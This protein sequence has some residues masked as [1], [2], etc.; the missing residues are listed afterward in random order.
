MIQRLAAAVGGGLM[1][2]GLGGAAV[3]WW[4]APAALRP[5][6]GSMLGMVALGAVM[7]GAGAAWLLGRVVAAHLG[8]AR[9]LAEDIDVL[10]AVDPG[11]EVGVDVDGTAA[12]EIGAVAGSV[13]GLVA[14]LREA[15]AERD[16][17]V[18]RG[19]AEAE[20]DRHRLG[21]VMASLAH[22]VLVCGGDGRILLYNEA[23]VGLFGRGG[24]G[25][26]P[27]GLGR[28]VFTLVSRSALVGAVR[29]LEAGGGE[30]IRLAVAG[31]ED[32]L[33]RVTVA[34][35]APVAAV[36]PIG[37]RGETGEGRDDLAG[38]VLVMDD[39]TA[40]SEA[41]ATLDDL[42]RATLE[43]VR[44]R[45]AAIVGAIEMLERFDNL[46]GDDVT[47][48]RRIISEESQRL[49]SYLEAAQ[50]SHG[51][52]GVGRWELTEI[53]ARDLVA[54]ITHRAGEDGGGAAGT[55]VE[56]AGGSGDLWFRV[57]AG[58]VVDEVGGAVVALMA[59][60]AERVRLSW[61]SRG[62]LGAVVVAWSDASGGS[63]EVVRALV[64]DGRVDGLARRHGGEAWVEAAPGGEQASM[65]VLLPSIERPVGPAGSPA[66]GRSALE[67]GRDR[68]TVYDFSLLSERTVDG[69]L[70]G[71]GL[72]EL[73]CTVFDL[74]TTGL[75]PSND[76][77]LSIGAVRI[78]NGNLL[79]HETFDQL[80]DPGRPIPPS[81]TS[82]HGITADMVAGQPTLAEALP[83][84]ARF[85]EQ[86]VLIGHN[87]AFD[88]RFLELQQGVT[89]VV[90]ANAVLDTLVLG[91]LALGASGSHSLESLGEMLGVEVTGR[92][93]ALG[94][95][96]V[97]AEI[98][99][100][101]V[102]VL[103]GKGL[104]SLAEV[105]AASAT[106]RYASLRY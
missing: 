52:T 46:D 100:K 91:E 6:I 51:G 76:R 85:V 59:G 42:V 49:T 3:I 101:L 24:E 75:D 94:D 28:S 26:Q 97:T 13:N 44:G 63:N 20:L 40:E 60:G 31:P 9:R 18:A 73:S 38:F 62:E 48:F 11:G 17:A 74:E 70:A 29:R 66:E 65:V 71:R 90:L 27:L 106:T 105:T 80:V 83:S 55:V 86:S 58:A 2:G 88:L 23:A 79:A 56:L 89:G 64:S 12:P 22:A 96:M 92:H 14:K 16:E 10:V 57:D 35:I 67:A 87:V 15:V 21:S 30:P 37:E 19:R 47:R 102:S 103:R 54:A 32:R 34:P 69:E 8:G 93:T 81:S 50:R 36:V 45:L 95:A 25:G 77:I 68:P 43:E 84:F 72:G 5:Q 98:F 1:L 82:I 61:Q 41:R 53:L 104:V 4:L 39:A 78:V 33:L 99:L 7:V